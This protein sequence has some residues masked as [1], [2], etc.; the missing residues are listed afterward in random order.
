MDAIK[1]LLLGAVMASLVIGF[2]WVA[3]DDYR[4][5]FHKEGK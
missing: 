5:T 4:F 2:I 3:V 1:D